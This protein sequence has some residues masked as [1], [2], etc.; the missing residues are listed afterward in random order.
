MSDMKIRLAKFYDK[1]GRAVNDG[2][3]FVYATFQIGKEDKPV[4][5][6]VLVQVTNLK[7]IPIIVAKYIIEKY[8]YGGYG[9]PKDVGSLDD[10][11]KF[12]VPEETIE[13]IRNICKSKGIDWI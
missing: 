2:D 13:E 8:G 5:G 12:G 10:V 6:D 11:K 9:K 4:E 1:M 7:G 3:E